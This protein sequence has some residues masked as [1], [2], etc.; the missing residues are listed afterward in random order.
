MAPPH[1]HIIGAGLAGLAAAVALRSTGSGITLYE[2]AGHAGGRCRSFFDD[3]LG[4]SID[5]GNHLL[6]SGNHAARGFLAAIGAENGLT[7]PARAAF[8]FIDL[9][10]AERWTVQPGRGRI[11][12][13]LFD[14]RRRVPGTRAADYLGAL[15]LAF[16]SPEATVSDCLDTDSAAYRRFWQ[17]LAVSA[18]NTAADEGAASLLWAVV[19]ETFGQGE[20]ACRPR[21]AAEG[22]SACFVDPAVRAIVTAGGSL[23]L[24]T[25]VAA[26]ERGVD[27]LTALH[28]AGG[29]TVALATADCVILAVPPA[30][31]AALVPDLR[32][33]SGSRAIVNAHFLLP[34]ARDGLGRP[35]P[36]F[37]GLVNGIGEWLFVRGDVASVTVSAADRL[38]EDP[39]EA[40]AAALWP[41]VAKALGIAAVA[42]PPHRI[43]KEKRATFAQTPA[44]VLRRPAA[45][46][47]WRN[48][49]LA[50]DWTAT[51]LPA[52]IEGTVRSGNTAAA[53]VIQSRREA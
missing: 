24:H 12:W 33:P 10:T 22:L 8:P 50:G 31:A 6:L 36:L 4:R 5:N 13:W 30:N 52:T 7:G 21:I 2:A 27:H 18:L 20:A 28:L 45:G 17:P 34:A 14:A 53:A 41:E 35:L 23:R 16:A 47:R 40:I 19:R 1:V 25:R 49:F 51:G 26:M 44:Q 48:L 46:T 43:V 39:A 9:A 15:R 37:L 32:V 11:P 3:R 29:E 38:A 42:L